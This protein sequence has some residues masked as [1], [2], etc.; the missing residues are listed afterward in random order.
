MDVKKCPRCSQVLDTSLFHKN[1]ARHDGLESICKECKNKAFRDKYK[2]NTDFR[3]ATKTRTRNYH[4]EHPEWSR[5]RL[6]ASHLKNAQK[7]LE[8]QK[9]ALAND[10]EKLKKA[11]ERTRRS[12]SRRRAIKAVTEIE[13]ITAQDLESLLNEHGNRCYI[14]EI[15]LSPETLHWDHYQPLSA[16][17]PHAIHNLRPS[18]NM[19]NVRKSA[20]WPITDKFLNEIK[21]TV[22]KVRN[23]MTSRQTGGDA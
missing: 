14:C 2:T 4:I 13:V 19:C 1:K 7:R 16:G 8:R 22:H 3:N 11:R 21:Q 12:E 9:K 6:R 17:G 10:P 20:T 15:D 23:P 18:C 5:E